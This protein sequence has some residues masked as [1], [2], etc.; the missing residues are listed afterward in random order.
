MTGESG[1]PPKQETSSESQQGPAPPA[2]SGSSG[3]TTTET[4]AAAMG[5][6]SRTIRNLIER[7]ELVARKVKRGRARPYEVD[8]DSLVRLRDEWMATGRFDGPYVSGDIV[9]GGYEET[10]TAEGLALAYERIAERLASA[11]ALAAEYRTRLEL[12]EQ[13]ESTR[14]AEVQAEADSRANALRERADQ[15]EDRLER[16][17]RR[18]LIDRILNR[19]LG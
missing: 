5:V 15:L 12:T 10:R 7:G 11:E 1:E 19:P 4:A 9:P 2:G 16:L 14:Q 3:W 18:G 13:A 6:T 17:Q 8:I